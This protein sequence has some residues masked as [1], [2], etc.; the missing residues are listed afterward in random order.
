[1]DKLK[2]W[3]G[4]AVVA[5]LVIGAGGWF[6]LISPKRSEAAALDA[7]ATSQ[8]ATNASLQTTLSMLKAQAKDL[9]KQQAKIAAVAAKI[10]DNPAL[11]ALI[12]SLD[13]AAL[14]AGV[15]LSSISPQAPA[16]DVA[17]PTGKGAAAVAGAAGVRM[18]IPVT[19]LVYGKYFQI[20][21]F[22]NSLEGLPRAMKVTSFTLQPGQ[23]PVH[24]SATVDTN[25]ALSANIT[26]SI[27]MASGRPTATVPATAGAKR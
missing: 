4:M 26:T 17:G 25:D 16:P 3:V 20:E 10:P 18:K 5:V 6:L 27:Y 15:D 2:Q 24:K 9:P 22:F 12:R 13:K 7:Q 21:Q 14:A 8:L 11:P 19:I 1:M 23:N